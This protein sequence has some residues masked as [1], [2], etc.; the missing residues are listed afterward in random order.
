MLK[1]PG[2]N[3]NKPQ[4]IIMIVNPTIIIIIR[5]LR[6]VSTMQHY[7]RQQNKNCIYDQNVIEVANTK[8]LVISHDYAKA[9]DKVKH[10]DLR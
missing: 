6:I 5:I 10:K 7:S 9:F 4:Q 3:K 8:E 1:K 2:V